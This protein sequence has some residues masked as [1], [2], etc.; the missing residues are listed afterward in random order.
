MTPKQLARICAFNS[1]H[2]YFNAQQR[3]WAVYPMNFYR[4]ASYHTR[5][6]LRA[7]PATIEGVERFKALYLPPKLETEN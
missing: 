3:S 4:E 5:E 7:F 1:H 2:C 6:T